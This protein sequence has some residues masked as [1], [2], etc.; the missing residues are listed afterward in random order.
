MTLGSSEAELV[1]LLEAIMN[2]VFMIHSLQNMKTL[3]KL[4]AME[5]VDNV[6]AIFIAGNVTAISCTKHI[7]SRYMNT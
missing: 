5:R 2:V 3:V 4:S 6:G 7:D 1:A